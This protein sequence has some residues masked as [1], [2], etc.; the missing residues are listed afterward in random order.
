M[1]PGDDDVTCVQFRPDDGFP[2]CDG[3]KVGPD[4]GISTLYP[5]P[6]EARAAHRAPVERFRRKAHA[7]L[8]RKTRDVP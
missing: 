1:R 6:E 5:T 3:Y 7:W 2:L 8:T 4:D